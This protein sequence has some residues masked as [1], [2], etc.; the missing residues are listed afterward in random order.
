[1]KINYPTTSF[2]TAFGMPV[3]CAVDRV[4]ESARQ[5]N[6]AVAKTSQR[7]D[8]GARLRDAV[9]AKLARRQPSRITAAADDDD[10]SFAE[11]L[12]KAVEKKQ[13]LQKQH[14]KNAERERSRYRKFTTGSV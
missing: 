9:K 2:A 8:F 4:I 7:Q 6:A 13:G 1:M 10:E 5:L 3:N 12:K 14:K 11:K